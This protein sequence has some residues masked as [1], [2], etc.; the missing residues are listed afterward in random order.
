MYTLCTPHTMCVC[1]ISTSAIRS[2]LLQSMYYVLC[3]ALPADSPLMI[4]WRREYE[5]F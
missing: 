2:I 5:Y 4:R 1:S 3:T